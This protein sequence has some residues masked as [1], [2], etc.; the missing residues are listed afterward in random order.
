MTRMA[1]PRATR[2]IGQ[3][4]EPFGVAP[5]WVEVGA[6]VGS[7]PVGTGVGDAVGSGAADPVTVIDAV[8]PMPVPPSVEVIG[9]VLLTL[10]PEVVP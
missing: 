2:S 8:A 7:A 9:S 3:R 1:T 6:G 5:D 4:L 10:V